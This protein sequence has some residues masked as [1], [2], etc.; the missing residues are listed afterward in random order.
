MSPSSRPSDERNAPL[1]VPVLAREVLQQLDLEPGITVVDGTIGAA[2]HS[3]LI[4]K[5]IEPS[6]TLIGIDRDPMM[7]SLASKQLSKQNCHLH[8]ANYLEL[9]DV[10]EEQGL[11]PTESV[12]RI[13]LDLGLSSDQ[14]SDDARGFSFHS[15]GPLDLRFDTKSGE[16]AWR[17]IQQ[18]DEQELTRLLEEFA[19]ERFSRQIAHELVSKR[20]AHPIRTATDLTKAI[21]R[22]IPKRFRVTSKKHPATRVFQAFRIAVNHELEHLSSALTGCLE[23]ALKPGG[24]LV[25]IT[26]HSLEDRIVKQAF[27]GESWHNLTKKPITATPNE[28]RMNPRCRTAK[29]RAAIKK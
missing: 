4:Q 2:G 18:C 22:A 23:S 13:L 24:R 5:E 14:L 29:L 9:H 17:L 10:L 25:V 6:G 27:R 1:H 16:P 15:E 11:S 20:R 19:E 26:F 12:D 8:H 3:K 28:L 21:E 7:L